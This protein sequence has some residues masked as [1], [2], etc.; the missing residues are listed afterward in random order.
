MTP[1]KFRP[2][3]S[4]AFWFGVPGLVFLLWGWWLSMGHWSRVEFGMG[5]HLAMP[6]LAIGQMG[7]GVYA[8]G[9]SDVGPDWGDFDVRHD[10]MKGE[11]ARQTNGQWV[12][13]SAAL[14]SIGY[15]FIPYHW[16]VLGYVAGWAGLVVSRARSYRQPAPAAEEA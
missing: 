15:V 5:H 6:L 13:A 4:R 7:G 12:A 8:W 1:R 9:N 3:R 10:A 16:L 2:L 14:P 11:E